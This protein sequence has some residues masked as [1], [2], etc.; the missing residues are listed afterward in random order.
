MSRV[1]KK[2]VVNIAAMGM[3]INE[4]DQHL[5][6]QAAASSSMIISAAAGTS[7]A[8]FYDNPATNV[9]LGREGDGST[10]EHLDPSSLQN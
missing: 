6:K 8:G 5:V 2:L 4:L 3:L 1:P 9:H 7:G 10:S